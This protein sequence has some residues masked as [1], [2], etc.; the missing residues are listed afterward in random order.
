M[1]A[2]S[3]QNK[4]ENYKKTSIMLHNTGFS[5]VKIHLISIDPVVFHWRARGKMAGSAQMI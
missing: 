4:I 2:A 5:F 1:S 3:Y